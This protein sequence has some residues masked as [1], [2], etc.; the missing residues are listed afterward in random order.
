MIQVR[1]GDNWKALATEDIM[2]ACFIAAVLFQFGFWLL[3][4]LCCWSGYIFVKLPVYIDDVLHRTKGRKKHTALQLYF[5]LKHKTS[6]SASSLLLEII[7]RK[8]PCSFIKYSVFVK[9]SH[10]NL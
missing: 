2:S 3:P 7:S 6:I 1:E 9:L 4:G 10:P 8:N 5:I